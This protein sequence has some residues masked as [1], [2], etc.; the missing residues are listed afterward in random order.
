M[1]MGQNLRALLNKVLKKMSIPASLRYRLG[2]RYPS[3]NPLMY[4][5]TSIE[6]RY[7]RIVVVRT[8][9]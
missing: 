8:L 2:N 9:L 6:N 1:N 7:D 3:M 4:K 5:K